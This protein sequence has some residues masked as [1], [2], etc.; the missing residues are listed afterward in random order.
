MRSMKSMLICPLIE[1][2]VKSLSINDFFFLKKKLEN[3]QINPKVKIFIHI[4]K[5]EN[6]KSKQKCKGVESTSYFLKLA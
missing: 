1:I 6:F 3:F 2:S 5:K 4:W